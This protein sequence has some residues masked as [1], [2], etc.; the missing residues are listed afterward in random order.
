M[1]A[2]QLIGYLDHRNLNEGS[3][4]LLNWVGLA[5]S[6]CLLLLRERVNAWVGALDSMR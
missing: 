3:F 6:G 5:G 1:A 4:E 2:K